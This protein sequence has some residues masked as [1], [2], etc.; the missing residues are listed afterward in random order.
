MENNLAVVAAKVCMEKCD[1]PA[2][3]G[4]CPTKAIKPAVLGVVPGSEGNVA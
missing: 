1:N 2:C 3:L 4:K